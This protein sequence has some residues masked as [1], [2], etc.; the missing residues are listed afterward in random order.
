MRVSAALPAGVTA[1]F[2]AAAE[3]R[4]RLEERL[5]SRLLAAGYAEVVLPILDYFEP[6]EPLL[7]AAGRGEL[8]RFIDRSGE[9]LALRADFTPMLA[10]LLAPRL[11]AL[12]MP[13]RL[14]YRGDV[15][16]CREEEAAHREEFYQLGAEI[17]GVAGEAADAEAL[18]LFL[19]LLDAARAPRLQVVLGFAGALDELLVAAAGDRAAELAA[20]VARR[21]RGPARRAEAA[22]LEV[23]EAGVPADSGRLGER[24]AAALVGLGRLAA[25][26]SREFPRAAVAVD[27]AEF[28]H[29]VRD[30]RLAAAQS[31]RGYYDGIV[32]RAYAGAR[33]LPVGA[34]G[35]YDSLFGRLGTPAPA[36]GLS[37]GLD[38]L[39]ALAT[40]GAP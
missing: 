36:L 35:R 12:A 17:L 31:P 21:E 24:A 18:R 8:Y 33:A 2:F 40:E 9:V 10:R 1:L 26:L 11:D 28:A 3:E 22:L 25:E 4:R 16:R 20:A 7:P 5:V 37:L 29:F 19:T 32:F 34:G 30:P 23:V 13:L 38:G 27:L 14:F 6:Y 39:A 15:V